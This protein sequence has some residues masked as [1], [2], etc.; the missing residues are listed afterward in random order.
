MYTTV[1]LIGKVKLH[2]SIRL[3]SSFFARDQLTKYVPIYTRPDPMFLHV[4][5]TLFFLSTMHTW[6]LLVVFVA[7]CLL[8][9]YV[10]GRSSF[11]YDLYNIMYLKSN[12][13][14]VLNER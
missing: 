10:E 13:E 9:A 5:V 6:T 14:D 1:S 4:Q 12:I 11:C 3:R 8:V 2:M 7:G